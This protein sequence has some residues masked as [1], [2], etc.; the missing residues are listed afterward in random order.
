MKSMGKFLICFFVF[1]FVSCNLFSAEKCPY[2]VK[3]QLVFD[4]SE[5]YDF[6]GLDFQIKNSNER[7]IQ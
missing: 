1:Q 6:M 2:S 4:D 3:A 7:A 5:C